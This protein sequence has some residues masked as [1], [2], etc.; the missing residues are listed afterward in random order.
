[1]NGD[2]EVRNLAER[3]RA[4]PPDKQRLT[5]QFLDALLAAQQRGVNLT[6]ML[7]TEEV[8]T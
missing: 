5:L 2:N 3:I 1:M 6:P 7:E 4:L 8:R